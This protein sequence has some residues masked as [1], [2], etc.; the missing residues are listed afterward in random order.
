M[1]KCEDC[2]RYIEDDELVRIWDGAYPEEERY[3]LSCP[4]CDSEYV[5][6]VWWHIDEDGEDDD[7]YD[8]EL[9]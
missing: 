6:E 1:W 2:G 4:Y 5:E 9:D 7:E 8:D 3:E